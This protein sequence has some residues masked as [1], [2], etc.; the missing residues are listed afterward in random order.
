M[1][2]PKPIILIT[3]GDPNGVGPEVC[4]RSFNEGSLFDLCTPIVIGDPAVLSQASALLKGAF[5][6]APIDSVTSPI[7]AQTIPVLCPTPFIE[8][9]QPG[10]ISK[11]AGVVSLSYITTA[12]NLLKEGTAAAMVTAPI[13]KEAIEP[14]VPGFQG[15]TEYIGEMCGDPHPVLTLIEPGWVISHVSTHVSLR[16]AIDRVEPV[17]I[18]KTAELLNNL[19]KKLTGKNAPKIGVAGLNPHAGEGGLFGREEIEIIAPTIAELRQ[20]GIDAHGPYPADVVF[21]QMKAGTFDGV[22]AMYHDQGHIV[23]KTLSFSL[24]EERTLNG[25]NATLG[26]DIIRTSVDH[27]TGFDIAWKGIAHHGSM[28]DAINC[29]ITLSRS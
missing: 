28:L 6:I 23:T 3:M 4:I 8:A 17:R 10:V 2:S 15:H 5:P 29:A 7:E 21:P 18:T 16:E 22:V 24:G 9:V 12:V 1:S 27:G 25:V 13:C 19:L 14:T 26:L 20:K 11:E